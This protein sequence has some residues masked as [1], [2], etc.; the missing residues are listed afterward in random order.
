MKKTVLL[1]SAF[2]MCFGTTNQAAANEGQKAACESTQG[3][4]H[5]FSKIPQCDCSKHKE[6]FP[7]LAPEGDAKLV[8][9]R[10]KAK[11]M[12]D[13]CENR[14]LNKTSANI[15]KKEK[16]AA[17]TPTTAA[18]PAPTVIVYQIL[19][20]TLT[21]DSTQAARATVL[22]TSGW[23]QI[24][25]LVLTC[26][27][28]CS[29]NGQPSAI[30]QSSLTQGTPQQ[31]FS[32]TSTGK[33]TGTVSVSFITKGGKTFPLPPAMPLTATVTWTTKQ[34]QPSAAQLAC[35][36]PPSGG[37]YGTKVGAPGY[38]KCNCFD[39]YELSPN[40]DVCVKK[41]EAPK[42][43]VVKVKKDVDEDDFGTPF[44]LLAGG[45]V[46]YGTSNS[47]HSWDGYVD[48]GVGV[49]FRNWLQVFAIGGYGGPGATRV[50][51][52][53]RNTS[54]TRNTSLHID[55]GT[56][57][58]LDYVGLSLALSRTA[59]GLVAITSPLDVTTSG[60]VGAVGI[61]P[62]TG[63]K[64]L[65]GPELALGWHQLQSFKSDL[66]ATFLFTV[67]VQAFNDQKQALDDDDEPETTPTTPTPAKK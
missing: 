32:L 23:K 29:V 49:D 9:I 10:S 33:D 43:P 2:L 64:V 56:L 28:G 35:E 66:E 61:I 59:R 37:L 42:P 51:A 18:P 47:F 60:Q 20:D 54:D 6:L 25:Q 45:T 44:H 34:P 65:F 4:W 17:P 13:V 30:V 58:H 52:Y 26:D 16:P 67:R 7:L 31:A 41:V 36:T 12:A 1:V 63:G 8:A 48:F 19:P 15:V 55:V 40:G 46:G 27:I 53:G 11:V 39:G 21:S 62:F 5:P 22:V 3:E 57:F 24:A 50:D 14:D 38:G